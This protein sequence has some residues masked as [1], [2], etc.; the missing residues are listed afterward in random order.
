[1][2][3][4]GDGAKAGAIALIVVVGCKSY[5]RVGRGQSLCASTLCA[6]RETESNAARR[7][8]VVARKRFNSPSGENAC[9]IGLQAH[10]GAEILKRRLE[11]R[12]AVSLVI[13]HRALQ[14]GVSHV[15]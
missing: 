14:I 2:S 3:V 13:G 1:M 4:S 5:D 11:A 8:G 7:R 9:V 10:R 15:D 12:W 6:G